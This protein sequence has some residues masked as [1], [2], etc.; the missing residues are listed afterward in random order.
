M[1]II[2]LSLFLSLLLPPLSATAIDPAAWQAAR[3]AFDAGEFSEAYAAFLALRDGRTSVALEHNLG[4][5]AFRK[6]RPDLAVLHYRRALWL[7][8]HDPDVRANLERAKDL[9]AAEIP[10]LP[11]RRQAA[12]LLPPQIWRTAWFT[13][14]WTTAIYGL[15]SMKL[16]R[17]A[18]SRPWVYPLL[19]AG[20]LTSGAG[21][22]G[23][24]LDPALTEAIITVPAV[25]ARFEPLD[26]ATQHFQLTAGAVVEKV[27]V[28]RNWVRI[29]S[30][31][32]LGWIP[33]DTLT[34]LFP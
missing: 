17:L 32:I 10:P 3:E 22:Y 8:P 27:D 24:R 26:T 29:R 5:S 19:A 25:T 1:K 14:L 34:P 4:N 13:L 21:L 2:C 6:G 12:G 11:A 15:L 30:N 16:P 9:L 23:S 33:A 31:D 28:S 20:L 18:F 7:D